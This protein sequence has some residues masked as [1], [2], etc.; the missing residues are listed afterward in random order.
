MQIRHLSNK[1][2]DAVKAFCIECKTAGFK[3]NSSLQDLKWGDVY[4]LPSKP[5]YWA[6]FD[7]DQIIFLAGCHRYKFAT[8]T[9]RCLFRSAS[10][11]NY[12]NKQKGLRKTYTNSLVKYIL[13][14]QIQYGLANDYD[15]FVIT[16]NT[17]NDNSGKMQ[18][19]HRVYQNYF[20][21]G[22]VE[23][24]GD[25]EYYYTQQSIWK[26]NLEKYLDSYA[27]KNLENE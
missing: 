25:V 14:E 18:K 24:L 15:Q 19:T 16:T 17:E 11:P 2:L 20:K 7:Q 22:I 8:N 6:A 1:D 9:L 26:V 23:Y 21:N 10:L 27:Y 5:E 4:D 12:K 13:H 3:N